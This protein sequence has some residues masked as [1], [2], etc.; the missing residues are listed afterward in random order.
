MHQCCESF[1]RRN[2]VR[3][4]FAG[5]KRS[6]DICLFVYL[7]RRA[8]SMDITS[9]TPMAIKFMR[10]LISRLLRLPLV[11]WLV[12]VAHAMLMQLLTWHFLIIGLWLSWTFIMTDS[13]K[14]KCVCCF[15]S[16]F[17]FFFSP[18]KSLN[19]RWKG[20]YSFQHWT[21][22]E[23]NRVGIGLFFILVLS[24]RFWPQCIFHS[25]LRV[26][27]HFFMVSSVIIL[28]NICTKFVPIWNYNA[29][30]IFFGVQ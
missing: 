9:S 27:F 14:S 19:L 29:R 13:A 25:M 3:S 24:Y 17:F 12:G 16:S 22:F 28:Y 5:A 10:L 30:K 18:F 11:G 1:V 2:V 15:F 6:L 7:F 4:P 21:Y 26:F 20:V 8:W 23:W